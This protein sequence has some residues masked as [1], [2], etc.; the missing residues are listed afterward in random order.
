M[1]NSNFAKYG[2]QK[3]R[4]AIKQI[5]QRAKR[6]ASSQKNPFTWTR[7]SDAD[8]VSN[9][10]EGDT[11]ENSE[12][13]Q[14]VDPTNPFATD[15]V[16]TEKT[17]ENIFAKSSA[18][19]PS[20]NAP[21]IFES[22]KNLFASPFT[23]GK[24]QKGPPV[25]GKRNPSTKEQ[26]SEQLIKDFSVSSVNSADGDN[27]KKYI[28]K[29]G[30]C[31]QMC[32]VEEFFKRSEQEIYS[33]FETLDGKFIHHLA[34]KEY[35]R[36]SADQEESKIE[37]LRPSIVLLKTVEYLFM[38]L[39]EKHR[40][41]FEEIYDFLW[42]R[43]R[44]IRKDITQQRL[45]DINT[46]LVL[47]TITRFHIYS[48]YVMSGAAVGSFE[49][50]YNN[51]NL[52]KTLTSLR[53]L[54]DDLYACS[55]TCPNEAEFRMY[56][57]LLNLNSGQVLRDVSKYPPA[58]LGS[59]Y[60]NYALSCY[61][62]YNS[63]NYVRF[64]KLFKQGSL[65]A[66]CILYRYI[67]NVRQKG[68]VSIINSHTT[69]G[70][71]PA[72]MTTGVEYPINKLVRLFA[73]ESPEEAVNFVNNMQVEVSSNKEVMLLRNR[74][75]E[76]N[77]DK[78]QN[79]LVLIDS[80]IMVPIGKII[81]TGE[82]VPDSI[83]GGTVPV[84]PSVVKP[85]LRRVAAPQMMLEK[86]SQQYI[87]NFVLSDVQRMITECLNE[88]QSLEKAKI[89]VIKEL[90]DEACH[91][92]LKE[93][94]VEVKNEQKLK[95]RIHTKALYEQSYPTPMLDKV[96]SDLVI[97]TLVEEARLSFVEET[98]ASLMSNTVQSELQSIVSAESKYLTCF[99]SIVEKTIAQMSDKLF[100]EIIQSEFKTLLTETEADIHV[101][102][103]K[104]LKRRLETNVVQKRYYFNLWKS[105]YTK[106][107]SK[108]HTL[109]NIPPRIIPSSSSDVL[110]SLLGANQD[111]DLDKTHLRISKIAQIDLA[112]PT[113]S[114][115]KKVDVQKKLKMRMELLEEAMSLKG[116]PLKCFTTSPK[117]VYVTLAVE[118]LNSPLS[119]FVMDSFGI[120]GTLG[121][122]MGEYSCRTVHLN[123]CELRIQLLDLSKV[124]KDTSRN[125]IRSC[126]LIVLQ[127]N[128]HLQIDSIANL[129][130]LTPKILISSIRP[131]SWV[132]LH[133]LEPVSM[134]NF[135]CC[136]LYKSLDAT[137]KEA[138]LWQRP[139]H[140]FKLVDIR[141][142]IQ[143]V[144]CVKLTDILLAKQIVL[145]NHKNY[146]IDPNII[147]SFYNCIIQSLSTA[148]GNEDLKL[149]DWPSQFDNRKD[150]SVNW[151]DDDK[152]KNVS[153]EIQILRLPKFIG[154]PDS[155]ADCLNYCFS[156]K[157][158][159][160]HFLIST[161][162]T[163]IENNGVQWC[164]I[165]N[166][167]IHHLI[168][169][170]MFLESHA[171]LLDS[172][173]RDIYAMRYGENIV[174]QALVYNELA[175]ELPEYDS[176][177][178]SL[179]EEDISEIWQSLS[180]YESKLSVSDSVLKSRTV[181]T[182]YLT[183]ESEQVDGISED[184]RKLSATIS[185]AEIRLQSIV[186]ECKMPSYLVTSLLE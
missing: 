168:E 131:H 35:K 132:N 106:I 184:L 70:R 83:I 175:D 138:L 183:C 26:N 90:L 164:L 20:T 29:K 135:Q 111:A 170:A 27:S 60:V 148:V 103:K 57:I 48:G 143:S 179:N 46:V 67:G 6:Q 98:S 17:P 173:V 14:P 22:D 181:P 151:N 147:I 73:F 118:S 40:N 59:Q 163:V 30:T 171:V 25:F 51:E 76:V 15:S 129:R 19:P 91:I 150:I 56:Y 149:I 142:F 65:L 185:E 157:T 97:E 43:T 38:N 101:E 72:N 159:N 45:C 182:D 104:E 130:V 36:A 92:A 44:A 33:N 160:S 115:Q 61:N 95:I 156:I 75:Y 116:I 107:Y 87:A 9:L 102:R 100:F 24:T 62:A 113:K 112:S 78:I 42:N 186:D 71:G 54:Y 139:F 158:F 66:C 124:T 11:P 21:L 108:R 8:N 79:R 177:Y 64:F 10:G 32:S 122:A 86:V 88:L 126:D 69:P 18:N 1:S 89:Y 37:D 165:L 176:H 169:N 128:C 166:Q 63:K 167:L 7:D 93:E 5:Q 47:E 99:N 119:Q 133:V 145:K 121:K 85:V 136:T 23:Q 144:L 180:Y 81:Y 53:H 153:S 125:A 80:K 155:T 2:Q 137:V 41:S 82:L 16:S 96:L 68:L 105:R 4:L 39:L 174:D 162:S 127:S 110:K 117:P 34:V 109:D 3:K 140:T 84:S 13:S 146:S 49:H 94:L 52:E 152:L 161:L 120:S 28:R 58:I 178:N 74:Q 55:E 172:Q 77:D 123:G 12:Y 134:T 31:M 154:V 50:K 141:D 114:Y